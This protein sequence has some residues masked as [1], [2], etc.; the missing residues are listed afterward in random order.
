MVNYLH[1]P[2]GEC[3]G[4]SLL[5]LC[6]EK[7]SYIVG[8]PQ[9]IYKQANSLITATREFLCDGVKRPQLDT[10]TLRNPHPVH[11]A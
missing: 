3:V 5:M 7:Q 9:P 4:L 1:T 11:L 6:D 10:V 8:L 2:G